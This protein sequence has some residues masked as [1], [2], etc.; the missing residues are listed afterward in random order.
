MQRI[1]E[2]ICRTG[3]WQNGPSSHHDLEHFTSS[4]SVDGF[5]H[6][7]R[8]DDQT[9]RVRASS[10]NDWSPS[11]DTFRKVQVIGGTDTRSKMCLELSLS[12]YSLPKTDERQLLSMWW[13]TSCRFIFF[14]L[15]QCLWF[16]G[17]TKTPRWSGDVF[18]KQNQRAVEFS[19]GVAQGVDKCFEELSEDCK[20][21]RKTYQAIAEPLQAGE[22]DLHDLTILRMVW[23]TEKAYIGP[24]SST[25][26]WTWQFMYI[27]QANQSL[28]QSTC[29]FAVLKWSSQT[30]RR[31]DMI[32]SCML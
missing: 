21:P 17:K 8:I 23:L 3:K 16:C 31:S 24:C 22:P 1:W 6:T 4:L 30:S 15:N 20:T 13:Q 29:S 32:R 12:Q 11:W 27:H 19:P 5:D 14:D 28:Y 18:K 2:R 25:C 26:A 10:I 7:H 9:L